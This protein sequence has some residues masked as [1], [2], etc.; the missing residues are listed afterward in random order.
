MKDR[1]EH[2][3]HSKKLPIVFDLILPDGNNHL[4]RITCST[5]DISKGGF[6]VL[7]PNHISIGYIADLCFYDEISEKSY[8]LCA[9][10]RWVAPGEDNKDYEIGF[11]LLDASGSDLPEWLKNL[12]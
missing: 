10:V 12:F 6:K 2:E 1:R 9:E 5:L 8:L 11:Q 3:R 7:S 4:K